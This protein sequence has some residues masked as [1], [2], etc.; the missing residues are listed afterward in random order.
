MSINGGAGNSKRAGAG[1][2]ENSN[3]TTHKARARASHKAGNKAGAQKGGTSP[4]NRHTTRGGEANKINSRTAPRAK[5]GGVKS[6]A[7]GDTRKR[8]KTKS[9][10]YN[11]SVSTNSTTHRNRS[12]QSKHG[13]NHR[14]NEGKSGGRQGTR[15]AKINGSRYR[16]GG[17]HGCTTTPK[18]ETEKARQT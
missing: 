9:G 4:D 12:A 11:L 16:G 10:A 8:R 3:R 5:A 18:P 14:T 7:N 15:A 6:G 2:K 17:G 1:G 13:G